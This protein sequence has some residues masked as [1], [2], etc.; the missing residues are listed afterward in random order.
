M[1]PAVYLIVAGVLLGPI[2]GGKYLRSEPD[3]PPRSDTE[4]QACV[5]ALPSYSVRRHNHP[6]G[7]VN[8]GAPR[9]DFIDQCR[10]PTK[11]IFE[12]LAETCARA[13]KE[14]GFDLPVYRTFDDSEPLYWM[15]GR[16]M[17][18]CIPAP[19]GLRK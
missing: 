16:H 11:A 7:R 14:I 19:S 8:A 18:Y 2:E 12:T 9:Q 10:Q 1:T 13:R 17:A 3:G 6:D 5:D 4:V 15:R